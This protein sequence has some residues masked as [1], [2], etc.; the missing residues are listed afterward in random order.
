MVSSADVAVLMKVSEIAK[1]F[2]LRPSE[3]DAFIHLDIDTKDPGKTF[4]LDFGG[5][6]TDPRILEKWQPMMR[7]LGVPDNASCLWAPEMS[8][9]ED[10]VDRALSVAPRARSV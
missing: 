4:R 3:A 2:G 9:I 7:A 10:A 6:P 8:V 1:R 5:T